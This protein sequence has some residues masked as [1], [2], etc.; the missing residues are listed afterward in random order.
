MRHFVEHT[1]KPHSVSVAR[2]GRVIVYDSDHALVKVLSPNGETLQQSFTDPFEYGS[3]S[4]AIHHQDRFFV[5]YC[6]K[7]RVLVFINDGTF[8]YDIGAQGNND[9]KPNGPL[10]LAI[11]KFNNLIVCD[12]NAGRLQVFTLEGSYVTTIT[13]FES[14]QFAAVSKDGQMYAADKGK[15]CVHVLY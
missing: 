4:F 7:H 2:D 3:P 14:P 1:K 5:S 6:E 12:S 9:E 8:L 15:E 13:G 11:D 10:G